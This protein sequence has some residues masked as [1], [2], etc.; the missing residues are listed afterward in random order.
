MG[1][2]AQL[3]QELLRHREVG[4]RSVAGRGLEIGALHYPLQLPEH[5]VVEYLDAENVDT[6]RRLFPELQ[7]ETLLTPH[8]L[9]DIGKQS[10]PDITQ[11]QF[12]F[13]ILSHVLEHVANPIQV[14]KHVWEGIRENGHLVL[15][16]PDKHFMFDRG[17]PLTTFLHLLAD[18]FRGVS[19]VEEDHYVELLEHVQP[20]VFAS[21]ETL[22]EALARARQRREHVHVWDSTT[23]KSFLDNTLALLGQHAQFEYES[24][25]SVNHFEYFAVL[26][27]LPPQGKRRDACIQAL[28]AVYRARPDLQ[29]VFPL[30]HE[31]FPLPLLRWAVTAGATIDSEAVILAQYQSDYRALATD[32]EREAGTAREEIRYFFLS[33]IETHHT[34]SPPA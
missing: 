34:P 27:K 19:E 15:A 18:Y 31:R 28:S 14:L 23:F 6:L 2:T 12:D 22:L 25:G 9:G 10:I 29:E 33:F 24:P 32:L 30:T 5:S 17:R 4:A 3:T 13:I 21:R 26:R 16:V 8:Y 1:H 7:N 11:H 20:E